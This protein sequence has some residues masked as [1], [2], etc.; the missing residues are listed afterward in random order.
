MC[1]YLVEYSVGSKKN[2]WL[3]L[4]LIVFIPIDAWWKRRNLDHWNSTPSPE[5]VRHLFCGWKTLSFQLQ[6]M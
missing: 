3:G 5:H 2:R 1:I 4:V 6:N